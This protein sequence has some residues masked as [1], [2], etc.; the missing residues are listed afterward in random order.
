MSAAHLLMSCAPLPLS[1]SLPPQQ[2]ITYAC[3]VITA[4]FGG[5]L[6]KSTQLTTDP[7]GDL[8]SGTS[9][10]RV[11]MKI[12]DI[13]LETSPPPSMPPLE[14]HTSTTPSSRGNPLMV[15]AASSAGATTAASSS[16]SSSSSRRGQVLGVEEPKYEKKLDEN[17]IMVHN[18]KAHVNGDRGVGASSEGAHYYCSIT[19]SAGQGEA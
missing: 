8:E 15:V 19:P 9:A 12:Y 5:A 7:K 6:A 13:D 18:G 3:R 16:S 2:Q 11:N 10:S 14:S 1:H 17:G 4:A